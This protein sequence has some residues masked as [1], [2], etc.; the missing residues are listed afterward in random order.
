[1][2]NGDES[3][4]KMRGN[5]REVWSTLD[6]TRGGPGRLQEAS[7]VR[8]LTA[9]RG[10]VREVRQLWADVGPSSDSEVAYTG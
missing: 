4:E 1:M 8:N 9:V 5:L 7:A 10:D 2:W 6:R 3:P